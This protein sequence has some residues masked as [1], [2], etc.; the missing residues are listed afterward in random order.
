MP[1]E[2]LPIAQPDLDENDI[3]EVM[4]TLRSGWLVYGAKTQQLERDFAAMVGAEHAVGVNSCT[5]G[6]HLSLL[7]AGIGPGDEVITTPLTFAAT[8]NVIVHVGATPVLADIC[9]DDLNIDPDQIQRRITPK[10]KAL[11]PVHYAGVP[12][13][14]DEILDIAER[15]GLRVIEDAATA[16][17]SAYKEKMVGAIGDLSC[18]SFY[19]VKNMTTGQGGMVTTNDPELAAQVSALR[20]HGLDSNAWKRYSSEANRLFYTMSQPGFNYGMFDLLA[21]IG[22]GQLKRLPAFNEKRRKL[23]EHYTRG[24]A[25]VSQVEVPTVRADVTTNWHLYVIRLRDT[26]VSRADLAQGLKERGIGTSVHYYPIHYHPYYRENYGFQQGDYPVTERE[27]ERILSLPLFPKMEEAD[28]DRVV[29]AVREV[30]G[31]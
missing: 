10:T 29:G 24:F 6:L 19:P 17:G 28:V 11:M 21:S 30:L 26:E 31:A 13:R 16:A 3:A 4:D 23:A 9:A 20:N 7:A 5:A 8:A 27:F 18:F 2:F 22:L 15:N 14:M 12:C 25:D 1:D